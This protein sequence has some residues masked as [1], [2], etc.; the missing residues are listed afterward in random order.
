LHREREAELAKVD[1]V[2][3]SLLAITPASDQKALEYQ[4]EAVSKIRKAT[5]EVL[6]GSAYNPII[7]AQR[8]EAEEKQRQSQKELLDKVSELG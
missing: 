8:K 3:Y 4:I 7:L 5:A 2:T 1:Y 6:N